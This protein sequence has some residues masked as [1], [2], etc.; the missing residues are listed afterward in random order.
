[1]LSA[2]AAA[3]PLDLGLAGQVGLSSTGGTNN[4]NGRAQGRSLTH[5]VAQNGFSCA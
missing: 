3:G 4:K 5:F 2:A 1:M